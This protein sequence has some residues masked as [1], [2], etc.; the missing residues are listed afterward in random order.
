MSLSTISV[1]TE[2]EAKKEFA[3]FCKDVGF[4][5]SSAINLFIKATLRENKIPF[6][7]RGDVPNEETLLAIDEMNKGENLSRPY[8]DV[9]ELMRD[10]KNA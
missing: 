2:P 10:L 9:D 6:E 4:N 1:K 3:E 8:S 7:I 5:M